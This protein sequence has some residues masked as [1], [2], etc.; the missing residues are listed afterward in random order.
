MNFSISII[1]QNSQSFYFSLSVA[2]SAKG[3]ALVVGLVVAVVVYPHGE[4]GRAAC[5]YQFHPT[6]L[7]D[8]DHNLRDRLAVKSHRVHVQRKSP[9]SAVKYLPHTD[10]GKLFIHSTITRGSLRFCPAKAQAHKQNDNDGRN[11]SRLDSR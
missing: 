6:V 9:P 2:K 7:F 10:D 5:R 11:R 3:E 1:V 4:E 8:M